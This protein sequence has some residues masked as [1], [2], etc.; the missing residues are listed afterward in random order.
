MNFTCI[1]T[2]KSSLSV[3]KDQI[4]SVLTILYYLSRIYKTKLVPAVSFVSCSNQHLY[5]FELRKILKDCS[6]TF[7]YQLFDIR[8]VLLYIKIYFHQFS[9]SK[10][11]MMGILNFITL[12]LCCSA[13]ILNVFSSI[14]PTP[15]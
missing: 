2:F 15:K 8:W 10:T 7:E 6:L 12:V 5:L 3:T 4:N 13:R 11:I 1:S 14:S 9:I